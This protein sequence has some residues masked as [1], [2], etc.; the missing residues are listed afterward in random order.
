MTLLMDREMIATLIPHSGAMCLL[1]GVLFWDAA[2]LRCV[3]W[4]YTKADNPLRRPDGTL[5]MACAI[6]L[7]GQAMALH[8]GL[9]A[10]KPEQGFL[11]SL[12]DVRLAGGQLDSAEGELIIEAALLMGD[13]T[14]ATYRFIVSREGAEL[15]SGR[16]TVKR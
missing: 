10:G 3:S 8:G 2:S 4:R 5:G 6:E 11:V 12:R 9:A 16:A 7:A 15:V 14:G 1:D 13:A